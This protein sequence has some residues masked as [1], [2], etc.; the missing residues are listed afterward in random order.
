[1]GI[2][3]TI[4]AADDIDRETVSVPE[5]GDVKIE[6]RG[7]D[8]NAFTAIT[9]ATKT[10]PGNDLDLRLMYINLLVQGA[11]DP[12][13][14]EPVWSDADGAAI[15]GKSMKVVERLATVINRLSGLNADRDETASVDAEGKDSSQMTAN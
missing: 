3:E 5:W 14:G 13:T 6:L 4:F 10:G 11:F 8:V 2:R 7:L 9:R 15:A 1:M 12:A